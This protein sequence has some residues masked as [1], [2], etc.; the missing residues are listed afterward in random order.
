MT[1]A[2]TKQIVE[3][4]E[5]NLPSVASLAAV[6]L[7]N[8]RLG[9]SNSL[10]AVSRLSMVLHEMTLSKEQNAFIDR[11]QAVVVNRAIND[12]SL[13]TYVLSTIDQTVNEAEKI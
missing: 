6:E 13:L 7:D 3:R 10:D 8:L 11:S 12:A 9:R 5:S 1:L 2:E 4:L